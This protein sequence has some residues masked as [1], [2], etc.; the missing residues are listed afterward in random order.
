MVMLGHAAGVQAG[1]IHVASSVGV[2]GVLDSLV[3]GFEQT[4]GNKLVIDFGLANLL[5]EKLAGGAPFDVA[6]LTGPAIDALITAGKIVPATRTDLARSGVGVGIRKGAAK[7][8]IGTE[9]AFKRTLLAAKSVCYSKEG[10]SG[11]YA[12]SVID[13]LG[14]AQPMKPKTTLATGSVADLVATGACEL[15]IQQ[16]SE[17]VPVA[18]IELVGP[19]PSALQSFT[20]FTTGVGTNA[21]DPAAAKAL[22]KFL[23]SPPATAAIKATGMDPG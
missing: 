2:Q 9:D 7:P 23:T 22:V 4:S 3:P 6:I 20:T 19:L 13:K 14:I 18:G 8:D 10:V 1:D 11:I 21:Q 16:V 15:G 12:A 5:K 17:I